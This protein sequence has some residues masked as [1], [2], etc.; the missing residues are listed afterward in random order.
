MTH[1]D[2]GKGSQQRPTDFEKFD[3]NFEKIFGKKSGL[4][5]E[6]FDHVDEDFDRVYAQYKKDMACLKENP[7]A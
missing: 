4:T 5:K 3:T 2:G 6:E 1:G 7:S